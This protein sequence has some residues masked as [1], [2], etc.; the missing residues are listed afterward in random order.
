MNHELYF[1]T[2]I[3]GED[4]NAD[5]SNLVVEKYKSLDNFINKFM[6]KA[7]KVRGSGYTF[8]VVD[9]DRELALVNLSNQ[10]NPYRCGLFPIMNLD[11]WEHAYF[12]DYKADKE[13]YIKN[14]FKIVDFDKVSKKY[15]MLKKNIC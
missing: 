11:L 15:E 12:L 9:K 8:L 3:S 13:Q 4:K 10:D 5:K 2:F 7:K 1:D 6:E 14:Y